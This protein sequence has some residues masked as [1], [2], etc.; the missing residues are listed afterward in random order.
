MAHNSTYYKSPASEAVVSARAVA[1]HG[2]KKAAH[3]VSVSLRTW[4]A[5]EYGQNEMPA[6]LFELYLIKTGKL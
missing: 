1:G 3:L 5:W 6:G 4:Q 2:Q